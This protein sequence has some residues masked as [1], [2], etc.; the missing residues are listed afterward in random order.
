MRDEHQSPKGGRT[1]LDLQVSNW[2]LR[3]EEGKLKEGG[4]SSLSLEKWKT[5]SGRESDF[6]G[7]EDEF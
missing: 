3:E 7:Q 6:E 4:A 5:Q 2:T 1:G